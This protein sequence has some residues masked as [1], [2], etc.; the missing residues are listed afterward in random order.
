MY[1]GF[2]VLGTKKA[3]KMAMDIYSE[4][5]LRVWIIPYGGLGKKKAYLI[6]ADLYD[7]DDLKKISKFLEGRV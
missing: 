4:L 2:T 5:R 1:Y 3:V 7:E 6:T